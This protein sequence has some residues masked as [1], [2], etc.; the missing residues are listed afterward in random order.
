MK[1][2]YRIL[3]PVLALALIFASGVSTAQSYPN[4]PIRIVVGF[5]PGGGTDVTSH[6]SLLARIVTPS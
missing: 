1:A 2:M 6:C 3:G 5:Q 4:R